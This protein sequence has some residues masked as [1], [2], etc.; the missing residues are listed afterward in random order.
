MNH[1]DIHDPLA[2]RLRALPRE[3]QPPAAAWQHIATAMAQAQC[4]RPPVPPPARR[5]RRP[6]ALAAAAAVGALLLGAGWWTHEQ[7]P[8]APAPPLAQAPS[9]QQQADVLAHAYHG[10]LAAIPPERVA[11]EYVPALHELDASAGSIRSAIAQ[12]PEAAFLL[13]QLRRTYALRLELTRQGL[14]VTES[15][16]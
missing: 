16:T 8:P 12:S 13:D 5:R 1:D 6:F 11:D 4:E 10:A 3:R 7:A 9:L 15:S 2:A 14:A